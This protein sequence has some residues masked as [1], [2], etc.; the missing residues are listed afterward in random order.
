MLKSI[1]DNGYGLYPSKETIRYGDTILYEHNCNTCKGKGEIK[2]QKCANGKVKCNACKNGRKERRELR[3]GKSRIF[4]E[5]CSKC[6]GTGKLECSN[7]KGSS[8]IKCKDCNGT[9]ILTNITKILIQTDPTYALIYPSQTNEKIKLA[10]EEF[11]DNQKK[12]ERIKYIAH[13]FRLDIKTHTEQRKIK[14]IYKAEI[15]FAEFDISFNDA[16]FALFIYGYEANLQVFESGGIVDKLLK[17]DLN[18]LIAISKQSS[19]A[20]TGILAKSQKIVAIFIES[21]IN[22]QILM[23]ENTQTNE[24]WLSNEYIS[25]TLKA[26]EKMTKNFC[27]GVTPKYLTIALLI[28]FIFGFCIDKYGFLAALGIFI[29]LRNAR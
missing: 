16:T 29:S 14:E 8:Y 2:C 23:Q 10:I 18:D 20:N 12:Y 4:Y 3:N 19:F 28:S 11:C 25:S 9:G 13:C 24:K 7:C 27:A 21:K 6:K 22:Q 5:T 17:K 15:P 26:F 1:A